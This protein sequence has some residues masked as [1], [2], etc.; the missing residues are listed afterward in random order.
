M[1]REKMVPVTA[2]PKFLLLQHLL[3]FFAFHSAV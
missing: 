1:I 2:P 3:I